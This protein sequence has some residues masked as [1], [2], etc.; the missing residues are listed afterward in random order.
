MFL[1][2]PESAV[3]QLIDSQAVY[4]EFRRAREAA[5]KFSGGMYFKREGHYEYL[6]KTTPDNRQNRLG[7]RNEATEATFQ[8]FTEGKKKAEDRLRSLQQA[9]TEAAR[10]NKALRV[11]RVPEVVV[12][13]LNAF[14]Q[15]GLSEYFTVIGTHALYAYETIGRTGHAGCRSALGRTQDGAVQQ[16][17]AAARR[18]GA[19]GAPLG[20][21]LVQ[22]DG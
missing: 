21:R 2:L 18:L 7:A 12:A 4:L 5:A 17:P 20:G 6:V 22:P 14:D 1:P 19:E 8:A 11:G 10:L 16:C 13:V 3:R 9:V 15:A